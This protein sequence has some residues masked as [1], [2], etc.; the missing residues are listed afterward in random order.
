MDRVLTL[1]LTRYYHARLRKFEEFDLECC[2]TD[3]ILSM[4]AEAS[5]LRKFIIDS[6]EEGYVE[7]TDRIVS[8]T[9]ALKR[10][11]RIL[12]LY[13]KKLGGP[14]EQ[15]HFYLCRKPVY[16]DATDKE[17]FKNGE[18]FELAEYIDHIDNK[19]DFVTEIEFC[20][21]S[22]A[23]RESWKNKTRIVMTEMVEFLIWILKKL[24]QQPKAMPVPLL[25]D[26]FVILLGLKLLQ[27]HGISVRE[28][29][30][31]LISRKFLNNFPNGEKIYDAL[32][33][34]IFYGILYDGK[35]R[36]VTELRHE[37][38]QRARSHPGISA[39]FIQASRDYL[40]KLSLDGPPFIIESGMHGTFP[41]WLLTLTDNV[42]DMVLYSTVPWMYSTYRDIVF[43][44]NY[45]Y[46]RDTETIVAHE[47]L[48]QFHAISDGKVL[49]KET[50]DE[51]I[52]ILALYELHIFKKLL[53]RKLTHLGRGEMT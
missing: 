18:P 29:R 43:R 9:N 23:Q 41:L 42:G 3:E 39:P 25:R 11:E 1:F 22:A 34:D 12:T 26:T 46:L 10:L 36:D 5:S 6:Y 27:Q 17:S 13:F 32:N 21:E 51:S 50:S 20:F 52:R 19:S 45:N 44:N 24:R 28:P 48:F 35:A 16:L 53:R 30:P 37:F 4:A 8:G 38:I 40:A 7:S 31:L 15:E 47:Y 2:T 14:S 49:V 33:S